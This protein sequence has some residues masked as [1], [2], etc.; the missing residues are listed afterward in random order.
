MLKE[1]IADIESFSEPDR[2]DAMKKYLKAIPG[3]YGEGDEFIG[4]RV[5]NL[6]TVSKS[7]Y[8]S[9]GLKD[10]SKL[11]S[12]PIHEFRLAAVFI[13]VLKFEKEKEAG[14]RQELVDFYLDHI[15]FMN[16]WDLIDSSSHKILGVHLLDRDTKLLYDFVY[17]DNLWL[18]RIAIIST[19]HFI[20]NNKF[21]DTF[22]MAEILIHH[23]H[24]LIHKAV[25]WMLREIGNRDFEEAFQFLKRYYS[26]MPR[27]MLRYA[28]EKY[29][30]EI[31]QDFLKGNI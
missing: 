10:L 31:R 28:I 12:S 30:E 27:T 15:K 9:I 7:Y 5:P 24:D 23:K 29:P 6:R 22:A 17:T 4:V 16:N 2:V 8:K 13:L 25:G 19:Y 1:I 14:K 18:Q 11:I 26:E 20:R 21:E 3:G